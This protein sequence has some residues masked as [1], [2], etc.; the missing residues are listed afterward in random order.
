MLDFTWSAQPKHKT[1]APTATTH[2]A[3]CQSSSG[4]AGG[5]NGGEGGSIRLAATPPANTALEAQLIMDRQRNQSAEC[6]K[7]ETDCGSTGESSKFIYSVTYSLTLESSFT[8]LAPKKEE[9]GKCRL[10]TGR[11]LNSS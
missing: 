8:S 3:T 2:S 11:K 6:R 1:A 5:R 10:S 4:G 7:S 9:P